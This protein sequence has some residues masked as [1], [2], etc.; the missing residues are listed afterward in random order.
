M[1]KKIAALLAEIIGFDDDDIYMETK[2][3]SEFGIEPIDVAKLVIECER[4]F[5]IEIMD[6]DVHTFKE[7]GDIVRYVKRLQEY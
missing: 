5:G 4:E 2:L 1:F 3:S 7:V 6:E